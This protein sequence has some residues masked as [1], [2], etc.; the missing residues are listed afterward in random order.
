[1]RASGREIIIACRVTSMP[2]RR[3]PT[4]IASSTSTAKKPAVF[5]RIDSV[6]LARSTRGGIF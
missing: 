2:P 4:L 3:Q 6:A 5:K 1:V